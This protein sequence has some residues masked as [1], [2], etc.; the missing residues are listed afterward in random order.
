M[1]LLLVV[2]LAGPPPDPTPEIVRGHGVD[3]YTARRLDENSR[4]FER[5]QR[6]LEQALRES[7]ER[8]FATVSGETA[9]S[10]PIARIDP[11]QRREMALAVQADINLDGYSISL[12]EIGRRL[13]Q[14][15][16]ALRIERERQLEE[17][18]IIL[19]LLH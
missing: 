17:E 5:N 13:D 6:E 8:A 16:Q 14:Y 7:I 10:E 15:E 19:L 1:S 12:A 3:A 4:E 18:A 11:P 2:G 9:P